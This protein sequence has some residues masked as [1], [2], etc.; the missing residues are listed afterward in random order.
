MQYTFVCRH[1]GLQCEPVE[2]IPCAL[3]L[4]ATPVHLKKAVNIVFVFEVCAQG[5]F[6]VG[7]FVPLHAALHIF[8]RGSYHRCHVSSPAVMEEQNVLS[9]LAVSKRSAQIAEQSSFC[10]GVKLCG[11]SLAFSFI[12]PESSNKIVWQAVSLMFTSSDNIWTVI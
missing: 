6:E 5:L 7:E 3:H 12:L 11:T 10:S 4:C 2:Q 9:L 8:V 1:L